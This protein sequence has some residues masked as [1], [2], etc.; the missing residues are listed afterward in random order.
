MAVFKND[1]QVRFA[2]VDAAGIMFY[3]RYFGLINDLVEDWFAGG[4]GTS[5]RQLHLKEK[6][7]VPT[8]H[9]EVDFHAPSKLEDHLVFELSVARL[10]RTSCD[11]N[12][13]ARCGEE[14][15]LSGKLILVH[16]DMNT[17]KSLP[18]PDALRAEIG[19][20]TNETGEDA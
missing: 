12:I 15:R 18:W 1:V 2:H 14:T 5:F 6:R 10:G 7:A 17:G 13:A 11:L 9:I 19:K 3:P 4:L 8:A 20:W 16:M